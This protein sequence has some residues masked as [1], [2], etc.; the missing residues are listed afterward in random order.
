MFVT[1]AKAQVSKPPE[2]TLIPFTA[3]FVAFRHGSEVG[4]AS[5]QLNK[6]NGQQYELRYKSEV[7]KFFFSDNR[8]EISTYTE[9]SNNQ[10][11][12]LTYAYKRTGTGPNKQLNVIF[13]YANNKINIDNNP[14]IPFEDQIDNQLF[15]ID[16][17]RQLSAGNRSFEYNFINYRGENRRYE[18]EVLNTEQLSLPYG[19]VE[20]VKVAV[21]RESSSRVTYGWFSPSLDYVLV[22][23]QQFKD[24]EEQGDIQLTRYQPAK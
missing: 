5:L 8:E 9:S 21:K 23:L 11:I 15:R 20:A 3:E 19:S 7:S 22:R 1:A 4:T 13:D 2:S 6:K 24:D 14:P 12:P 18:I 16:I 10:L 17:S